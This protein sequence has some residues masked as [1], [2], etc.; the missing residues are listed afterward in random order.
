MQN[1]IALTDYDGEWALKEGFQEPRSTPGYLSREEIVASFGRLGV[2][3]LELSD[4]YWG[5]C[6][7]AYIK[8]LAADCGL[9]LICYLFE[10]DLTVPSS[11]RQTSLDSAFALL[12]RTAELGAGLAMIVPAFAK[13]AVPLAEQRGWLVEGLRQCA[14]HAM[15][16]G[17]T[18]VTENFDDPPARRL[19]SR[20]SDCREICARV[21]SPAYRLIYDCGAPQLIGADPLDTLLQMA[22]FIV[23]VHLKNNRRIAP[24]EEAERYYESDSGQRYAGT[25]LD[26]GHLNLR[27]IMVELNRMQYEGYLLIEYQG[28]ED[29]RIALQ[30]NVEYVRRLMEEDSG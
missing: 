9:T 24:G 29:P 22:P 17:V 12:D 3:G 26:G 23:H 28:V 18:L 7:P 2:E 16:I 21:D 25:V 30:H 6:S 10:A 27:R 1:L 19:M 4:C 8:R 13:D 14:E 15:S 11:E 20:G 5:D